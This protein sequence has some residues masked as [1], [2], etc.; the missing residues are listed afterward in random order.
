MPFGGGH[1]LS[2]RSTLGGAEG[3]IAGFWLGRPLFP[4]LQVDCAPNGGN[5]AQK[6]G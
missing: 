3:L 4:V 6:S 5:Y 1:R 2:F